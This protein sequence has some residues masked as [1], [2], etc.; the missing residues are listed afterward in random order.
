M[1]LFDKEKKDLLRAYFK[2]L[3]LYIFCTVIVHSA[4]YK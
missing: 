3:N 2:N 1:M 4:W